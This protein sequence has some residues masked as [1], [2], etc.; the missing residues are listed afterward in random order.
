MASI[1]EHLVTERPIAQ[2]GEQ[3]FIARALPKKAR[4]T[5]D[6]DF[7]ALERLHERKFVRREVA[8]CFA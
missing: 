1:V 3:I 5:G 6:D 2:H 4:A 7:V 8:Q